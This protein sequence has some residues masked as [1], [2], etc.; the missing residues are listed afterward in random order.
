MHTI[1]KIVQLFVSLVHDRAQRS[2]LL[3][4]AVALFG[5]TV[6]LIILLDLELVLLGQLPDSGFVIIEGYVARAANYV[7][8]VWGQHRFDGRLLM[9]L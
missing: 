3:H 8:V 9:I 5:E 2:V 6:P 1:S 4:N 7:V